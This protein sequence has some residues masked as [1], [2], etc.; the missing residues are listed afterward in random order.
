MFISEK[1]EA[2]CEN[3]T[4]KELAR[5]IVQTIDGKEQQTVSY[6]K[7]HGGEI[8][9]TGPANLIKATVPEQNIED[10]CE[11]EFIQAI[12]SPEDALHL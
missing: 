2:I 6:I 10:L 9:E 5:I 1:I 7:N 3:P 11:K 4:K 12:E 8:E